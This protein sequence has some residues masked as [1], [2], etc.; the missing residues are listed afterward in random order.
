MESSKKKGKKGKDKNVE[1][2]TNTAATMNQF[3]EE[4]AN[5]KETI[6]TI[7]IS[8]EEIRTIHD[9]TLNNVTSEKEGAGI[10]QLIHLRNCPRT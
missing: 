7:K 8:V 2:P 4:I 10:Y 1:S 3:F 9:R 6:A 5:L